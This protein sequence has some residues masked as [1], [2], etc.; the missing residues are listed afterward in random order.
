MICSNTLFR[1][2]IFLAVLTICAAAARG[3]EKP[4]A[5]D[6]ELVLAVD[7]S[8]S[9]DV[10]E[11]RLQREGYVAALAS[12]EVLAAIRS[13]FGLFKSPLTRS[14]ATITKGAGSALYLT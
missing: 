9:V 13:G 10:E 3:A 11:A 6:L 5:V 7:V 2:P 4:V 12:K 1:F 8:G 14:P